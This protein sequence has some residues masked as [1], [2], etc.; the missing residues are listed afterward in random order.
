MERVPLLIIYTGDGKGKTTAALGLLFRALG[1]GAKCA[2]LQCIKPEGLKTGEKH[3]ALKMGVL[4]E[5]YGAG[6]LWEDKTKEP[7]RQAALKGWQRAKELLITA[8]LD[9][10]ILDELTYPLQENFLPLDEVVE[11]LSHGKGQTHVVVTGRNA[12]QALIEEADLVSE[13]VTVKHPFSEAQIRAQKLI[14]Y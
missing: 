3:S 2:V 12:P 4:W 14:E 6:F 1:H 11:M 10:L 7:S 9:L 8:E 13:I 5:N